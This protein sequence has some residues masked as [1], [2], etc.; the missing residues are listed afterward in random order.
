M[1]KIFTL[2]LLTLICSTFICCGN[3]QSP[4]STESNLTKKS[5]TQSSYEVNTFDQATISDI[6]ISDEIISLTFTYSGE[7]QLNL[8]AWFIVEIYE[9]GMWYTLPYDI[10]NC[11]DL[12]AYPVEPNQ[13]KTMEYHLKYVYKSLSAGKYRIITEV[14]DFVETGNYTD[15]YLAAE[16]EIK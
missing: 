6:S 16:F 7:N 12:V 5:L 9:D 1:K 13:S 11:F 4:N 8:G 15:Y 2:C 3:S 10:E 14:S